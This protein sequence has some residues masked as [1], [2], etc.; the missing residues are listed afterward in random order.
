MWKKVSYMFTGFKQ[1]VL[2]EE[3]HDAFDKQ[4]KKLGHRQQFEKN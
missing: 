3:V 2:E 4:V 1:R